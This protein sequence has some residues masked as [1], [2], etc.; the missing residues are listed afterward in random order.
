M[1]KKLIR[2]KTQLE[3]TGN[4]NKAIVP[5][6]IAKLSNHKKTAVISTAAFTKNKNKLFI[7]YLLAVP[8]IN[9][10]TNS[11]R[12]IKNKILAIDA[13]L[14]DCRQNP[15]IAATIATIRKVIVQ[16][17]IILNI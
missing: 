6:A 14:A 17:N 8:P 5:N 2:L 7:S 13:A 15:K 10:I 4:Q 1:R 12:N 9:E 3:R 11:T 16:R